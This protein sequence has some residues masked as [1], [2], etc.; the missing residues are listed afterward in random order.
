MSTQA[1]A[2]KIHN[3]PY[4]FS[5]VLP[6]K[7]IQIK[8]NDTLTYADYY[9]DSSAGIFLM[10]SVFKT[11]F[12]S[13]TDYLNCASESLERQ[14]KQDY[15]DTTLQLV[16]CNKS[17]FYPGQTNVLHFR[18]TETG[19]GYDTYVI[20]FIHHHRTDIQISF[21]FRKS[22]E[23]MSMAYIDR[24]MNTLKLYRF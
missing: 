22:K 23:Q 20:Y 13:A 8:G 24:I 1:P 7:L 15:G 10:L 6:D 3:R 17:K 2:K 14:L 5:I 16:S 19:N 9:F 11:K 4:R 18:V 12:N 21:T